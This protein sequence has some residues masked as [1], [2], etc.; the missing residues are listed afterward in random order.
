MHLKTLLHCA[1]GMDSPFFSR[2]CIN[3]W[4]LT[5]NL[6]DLNRLRLSRNCRIPLQKGC[7]GSV[8]VC[9]L[10]REGGGPRSPHP[11]QPFCEEAC[12]PGR[13]GLSQRVYLSHFRTSTPVFRVRFISQRRKPQA[14]KTK[15]SPLS[16]H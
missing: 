8:T 1:V 12:L 5:W 15:H 6:F 14:V 16:L 3:W 10:A 7:V 4:F 9:K 2:S 13:D 11:L